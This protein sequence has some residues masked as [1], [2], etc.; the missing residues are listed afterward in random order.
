MWPGPSQA[1]PGSDWARP[2][3]VRPG[4]AKNFLLNP[5]LEKLKKCNLKYGL[6]YSHMYFSWIY[7]W[8]LM[9]KNS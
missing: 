5:L 6:V 1:W 7:G 9:Y 8:V 3:Q 4:T 2:A